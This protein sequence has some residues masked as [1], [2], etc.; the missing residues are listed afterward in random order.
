M[1]EAGVDRV[2]LARGVAVIVAILVPPVVFVRAML[3]S[4]SE[5][6]LWT[7]I[8][9]AFV[10]GF[11]IGGIAAARRAPVA[12]VKHAALAGAIA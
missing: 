2:A 6:P 3:G 9:L 5:S 11:T 4:E 12:P 7:L 8:P 1:S 10:L